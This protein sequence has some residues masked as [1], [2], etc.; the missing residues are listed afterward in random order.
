MDNQKKVLRIQW[1]FIS[2]VFDRFLFISF[3][4][5]AFLCNVLVLTSS[6]FA[7][8]FEYCPIGN[9]KECEGMTEEQILSLSK[10]MMLSEANN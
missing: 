3:F 5:G 6:P 8:K 2:R 10:N 7:E 1:E 9:F 4:I